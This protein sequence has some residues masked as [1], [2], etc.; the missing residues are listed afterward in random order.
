VVCSKPTEPSGTFHFAQ[1]KD[2][3]FLVLTAYSR[4]R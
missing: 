1:I 4:L 2:F 3:F